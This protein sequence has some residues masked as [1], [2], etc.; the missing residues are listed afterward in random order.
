M[1]KDPYLEGIKQETHD[2]NNLLQLKTHVYQM[3][4]THTE[5]EGTLN[6]HLLNG[7]MD[8]W[9]NESTSQ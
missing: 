9:M 5:K 6:T 8:G 1:D 4:L 7:W 3:L 2:S